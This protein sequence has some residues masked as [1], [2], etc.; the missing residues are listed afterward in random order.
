MASLR[1]KNYVKMSLSLWTGVHVVFELTQTVQ[2][3]LYVPQ[4]LTFNN[5]TF[6]PHRVFRCVFCVDLR[7]AIYFP[8]QH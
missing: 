3:S 6:S 4:S 8:I 2:W 5:S 1:V 7:T